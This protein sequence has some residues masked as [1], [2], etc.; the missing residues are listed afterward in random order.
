[1][2]RIYGTL[3]VFLVHRRVSESC[4]IGWTFPLLHAH[5]V[6]ILR[7]PIPFVAMNEQH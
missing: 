7:V 2:E 6:A 1:M 4:P 5:D 3:L